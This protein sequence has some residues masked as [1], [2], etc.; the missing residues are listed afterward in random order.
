MQQGKHITSRS[1]GIH[2]KTSNLG[3]ERQNGPLLFCR[4]P[5]F[6]INE[7]LLRSVPDLDL[8][9]GDVRR[10]KGVKDIQLDGQHDQDRTGPIEQELMLTRFPSAP[11]LP[12]PGFR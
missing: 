12:D 7:P 11:K 4:E 10:K 8:A 1:S 2:H 3:K 6:Y 5:F 9:A